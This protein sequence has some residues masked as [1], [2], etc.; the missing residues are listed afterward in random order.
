VGT[1]E[2]EI[3]YCYRTGGRRV[4]NKQV[5]LRA[6][7]RREPGQEFSLDGAFLLSFGV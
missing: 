5:L 7:G 3:G 4:T 6:E 2:P 1:A